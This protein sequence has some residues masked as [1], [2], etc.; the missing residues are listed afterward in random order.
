MTKLSIALA[1]DDIDWARSRVAA[2]EYADLDPYFSQLARRDRSQAEDAAWVQAEIDKGLASGIDPRSAD[3]IF[4]EVRAE[5][6]GDDG[7]AL[8]QLGRCHRHR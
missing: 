6:L 4:R 8:V 2:G 7:A 5:Y 1:D 3:Q